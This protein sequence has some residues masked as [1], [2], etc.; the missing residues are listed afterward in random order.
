M[1]FKEGGGGQC[2]HVYDEFGESC[3]RVKCFFILAGGKEIFNKEAVLALTPPPPLFSLR[4]SVCLSVCLSVSPPPPP[5]HS[6][7]RFVPTSE[8][9]MQESST[10]G[11]RQSTSKNIFSPTQIA[12]GSSKDYKW[13]VPQLLRSNLI[14]GEIRLIYI[15]RAASCC[16]WAL[17]Q[18]AGLFYS[19][20]DVNVAQR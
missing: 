8:P 12:F 13:N 2:R 16:C 18:C 15:A 9:A 1:D 14:R 6:G 19:K 5:T 3:H 7:V 11:T 4:L 20:D 17:Q 10:V